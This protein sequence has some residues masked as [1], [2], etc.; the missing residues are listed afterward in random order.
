MNRFRQKSIFNSILKILKR[1]QLS[2]IFISW[3]RKAYLLNVKPE[4][5]KKLVGLDQCISIPIGIYRHG[6]DK[7]Q[8]IRRIHSRKQDY[9]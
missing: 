7:A 5:D 2:T 6:P 8:H 9:S 1:L 4:P 3:Q